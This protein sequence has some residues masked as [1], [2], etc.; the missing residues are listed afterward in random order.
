MSIGNK[1]KEGN[2]GSNHSYQSKNIGLLAK[3]ISAITIFTDP[4]VPGVLDITGV[5]STVD[6][7]KS[8]TFVCVAGTIDIGTE[9]F[10]PGAYT[11]SNGKGSLDSIDYDASG[12]TDC[13]IIYIS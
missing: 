3:I 5:G 10:P 9:T 4:A 2:K 13:K 1:P 8:F 7:W 12:S 11:F 6:T